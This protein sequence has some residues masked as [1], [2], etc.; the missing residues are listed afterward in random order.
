MNDT[1]NDWPTGHIQEVPSVLRAGRDL[2][3]RMEKAEAALHALEDALVE[4]GT[5][6]EPA[7]ANSGGGS[8]T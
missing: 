4:T 3:E 2:L 6:P 5:S 7:D 1:T 8:C